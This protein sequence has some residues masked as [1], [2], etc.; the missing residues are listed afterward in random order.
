MVEL[1]PTLPVFA[2]PIPSLVTVSNCP[3]VVWI[4]VEYARKKRAHLIKIA[5]YFQS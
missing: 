5:A 1:A 4:I 2:A 3:D